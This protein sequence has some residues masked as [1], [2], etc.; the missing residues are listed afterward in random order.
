M[1]K[2]ALIV[3][4]DGFEEIEAVTPIDILR[5]A[6]V[7]VVIAGL[8]KELVRGS[9]NIAVKADLLLR[10]YNSTP[11]ALILPGGAPGTENLAGSPEVKN[12]VMKMFSEE[13]LIAAICAAP[14]LILSPLGIL[15]GKRATCFPGLETNFSAK[16][17]HVKE[18]V[19]QDGLIITSCGA[20]GAFEFGLKITEYLAGKA[21]S[22][23]LAEQMCFA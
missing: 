4:A 23:M 13:K 12:L 11:D 2:E 7:N 3:L 14:A 8:E 9:H 16:V 19:V 21:K 6:G 15:D 22:E 5:R 17:K 1:K 10:D 20:G 18:K